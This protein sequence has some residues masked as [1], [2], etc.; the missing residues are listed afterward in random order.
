MLTQ[1]FIDSGDPH[2]KLLQRQARRT[3]PE[4]KE[5]PAARTPVVAAR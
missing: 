1:G 4:E 5:T 2:D 3:R